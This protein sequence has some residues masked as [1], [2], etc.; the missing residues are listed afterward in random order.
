MK[1]KV[2][3][4][5]SRKYKSRN[6][7]LRIITS[8]RLWGLQYFWRSLMRSNNESDEK[9]RLNR[10]KQWG[11]CKNDRSAWSGDWSFLFD[12]YLGRRFKLGFEI[13]KS[14]CIFTMKIVFAGI[15][16]ERTLLMV[17][18]VYVDGFIHFKLSCGTII[19]LKQKPS[20][21]V[22]PSQI[23]VCRPSGCCRRRRRLRTR[24]PLDHRKSHPSRHRR[25]WWQP[26]N[27][28]PN[29]LESHPCRRTSSWDKK[30]LARVTY[31]MDWY[32]L[33]IP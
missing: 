12:I 22:M 27:C 21:Y 1:V 30:L 4:F 7:D 13:F 6:Y 8:G 26:P 20:C 18:K 3:L 15:S 17:M 32:G 33:P 10:D 31:P 25:S 11:C 24:S 5:C 29:R 28:R 2:F 16:Q 9:M 19:E 23:E 14:L